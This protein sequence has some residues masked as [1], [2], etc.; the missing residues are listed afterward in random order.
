VEVPVENSDRS[1]C[2][3]STI[4]GWPHIVT[5]PVAVVMFK[6]VAPERAETVVTTFE[7][8]VLTQPAKISEVL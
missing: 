2:W 8:Q 4:M 5:G 6:F 7:L 3:N 1:C